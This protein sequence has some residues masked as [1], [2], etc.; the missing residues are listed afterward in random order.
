MPAVAGV[1]SAVTVERVNPLLEPREP[2]PVYDRKL[3]P[4]AGVRWPRPAPPEP[5]AWEV[6][7]FDVTDP[8]ELQYW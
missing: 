6:A 5:Q 8:G 1:T 3:R 2:V 7:L 4:L